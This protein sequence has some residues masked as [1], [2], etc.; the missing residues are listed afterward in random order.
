MIDAAG[1]TTTYAF[2]ETGHMTGRT[3]AMGITLAWTYDALGNR[4]TQRNLTDPIPTYSVTWSY[5]PAGRILTRSADTVTTTYEYDLAGNQRTASASGMTI[6]TEYDRLNRVLSVDDEDAGTTA[7]TSYTYSLTAPSWTDPTGAYTATLDAFDRATAVH[8]PAAVASFTWTFGTGGQPLTMTA[9]NTNVTT[10]AYDRLGRELDRETKTGSTSRAHYTWTYNRAGLITTEAATVTG[11]P[12][13]GTVTHGYD[14]LGQLTASGLLGATTEYGWDATTNRNSVKVGTGTPAT[15]AYDAANRPT[16]GANPT[17]AYTSDA[18][19]RLTARPGQ[20]LVWDHLGR[21]IAVTSPTDSPIASYSY[22]PLDRLRIADDGSAGRTRF[23]YVASTTQVAQW[24][25]DAMGTVIRNVGNGWTGERLIDWTGSGTDPRTYGTNAHHD[26]T[27]LAGASGAVTASLR[28]DPWGTPRSPVPGGYTPFRFQ[29]SWHDQ[30]PDLAWV[31]TRWY[32]P[33]LGRFI[34]ED[35]LL[36][37]P[38]E[39]DSRHL[40]AYAAGEPVGSWDPDGT[41]SKSTALRIAHAFLRYYAVRRFIWH[42]MMRNSFVDIGYWN[43]HASLACILG[44]TCKDVGAAAN[45]ALLLAKFAVRVH[46][47][48]HRVVKILGV[49]V[50]EINVP[51]GAWDHKEQLLRLVGARKKFW[52]PVAGDPRPERIKYDIWS[53]IH[54]GFVGRAHG[55]PADVLRWAAIKFGGN[56]SPGD[57]LSV[58]L[59]IRLWGRYAIALTYERL[60]RE[61]LTHMTMYRSYKDQVHAGWYDPTDQE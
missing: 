49:T 5:D 18:D 42:Q 2:D 45:N 44:R 43:G 20:K 29:G 41:T 40:Y 24:I 50:N 51:P 53:N 23:R 11:D 55:I 61:V 15:T 3:D 30:T 4:V 58:N 6:T 1:H 31:V 25:D 52:T 19:G 13:N 28:Y 33:S 38:R 36:G 37:T 12:A 47:P 32:A 22:D 10:H 14:Q 21:L 57:R 27:W 16:S 39:P 26:V 56:D 8:T 17:A 60:Q 46:G 59:G 54:Y 9:P 34:S 7:D 35:S 48:I